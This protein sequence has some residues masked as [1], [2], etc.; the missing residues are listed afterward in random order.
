MPGRLEL[1]VM[2]FDGGADGE[3]AGTPA[4][5]CVFTGGTVSAALGSACP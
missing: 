4:A 1:G 5:L 2:H 3:D